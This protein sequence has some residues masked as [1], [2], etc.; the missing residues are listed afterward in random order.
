M[1]PYSLAILTIFFASFY[2]LEG[3]QLYTKNKKRDSKSESETERKNDGLDQIRDSKPFGKSE[4]A[5]RLETINREIN[6][7]NTIEKKVLLARQ[8]LAYIVQENSTV[9]DFRVKALSAKTYH[10]VLDQSKASGY[11]LDYDSDEE[12][13]KSFLEKVKKRYTI[14]TSAIAAKNEKEQQEKKLLTEIEEQDK[15]IAH[16]K[17]LLDALGAEKIKQQNA[18]HLTQETKTVLASAITFNSNRMERREKQS[19][20]KLNTL[21]EA[22]TE[23]EN[24]LKE[25]MGLKIEDSML[26][27]ESANK[28]QAIRN[29]IE[30]L[31]LKLHE[32]ETELTGISNKIKTGYSA[33]NTLTA[34]AKR[35]SSYLF[36]SG[37]S[38]E[39]TKN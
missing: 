19:E 14:Y 11:G 15:K 13:E 29:E 10:D 30:P 28:A 12:S 25:T 33:P 5:L 27:V 2:C 1:K 37:K 38:T 34:N 36:S 18:L 7:D 17:A 23:K 8:G 39:T 35:F 21:K 20:Q 3:M 31:K 26:M 24:T 4:Y 32:A 6:S 22:I 16:T 9:E